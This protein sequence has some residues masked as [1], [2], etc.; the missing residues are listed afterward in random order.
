MLNLSLA[1]L[2]SGFDLTVQGVTTTSRDPVA[3]SADE[4]LMASG[5]G[6]RVTLW[7]MMTGRILRFIKT[8]KGIS[9]IAFEPNGKV[10]VSVSDN[11]HFLW[12]DV[13]SGAQVHELE[14]PPYTTLSAGSL[15][16][17]PDG[18]VMLSG[19]HDKLVVWD[20]KAR[21][22]KNTIKVSGAVT[23]LVA[24]SAQ[25]ALGIAGTSA[26]IIVDF[27]SGTIERTLPLASGV[28]CLKVSA[29]AKRAVVA[30]GDKLW[31]LDLT[32]MHSA[33]LEPV[34]VRSPEYAESIQG[35]GIN[36][37]L[38][39]VAY[40]TGK[41]IVAIDL[42][43]K[44]VVAS[45]GTSMGLN[46][47]YGYTRHFL[48]DRIL[49]VDD[50][51]GALVFS[52]LQGGEELRRVPF[53][54]PKD[55]TPHFAPGSHTIWYTHEDGAR[56]FDFELGTALRATRARGMFGTFS[57]D[58]KHLLV[59]RE[60]RV[61]G[62]RRDLLELWDLQR[63]QLARTFDVPP[64]ERTSNGNIM[65]VS[66]QLSRDGTRATSHM[67]G[68]NI[69]YVWDTR[70]GKLVRAID[71]PFA[72]GPY[73]EV[74]SPDGKQVISGGLTGMNKYA[75]A[76]FDVGTGQRTEEWS[77]PSFYGY[78][79]ELSSDGRFLVWQDHTGGVFVRDMTTKQIRNY[80]GKSFSLTRDS[81][82]LVLEG[83]S[84]VSVVGLPEQQLKRTI[85]VAAYTPELSDDGNY[86]VGRDLSGGF[87]LMN[88]SNKQ[89]VWFLTSSDE[90]IAYTDDGYFDG[91]KGG[92]QLLNVVS[93]MTVFALDQ[94]AIARNRPEILLDRLG[95]GSADLNQ[96]YKNQYLKRLRKAGITEAQ[97]SGEF[98][99][100]N[101]RISKVSVTGKTA[102]IAASCSDD[103]FE[104]ERYQVFVNDVPL[105]GARGKEAKGKSAALSDKIQLTQ[106]HNKIELSCT[107]RAGAESYRA[108]AAASS[109]VE[110]KSAL[111][112]LAFGVSKYKS[113]GLDLGFA[114]KDAEDLAK[115]LGGF[116][117]AHVKTFLNEAVT[118]R[119][120]TEAKAFVQKATPDDVFVLFIAGHGV[121]DTD[122]EATYYYLTHDADPAA[123]STTAANFDQ[124]EDL[125]QGIA[126][127]RKLFLMDTCESG[128]RD[129]DAPAMTAVDLKAGVRSRGIVKKGQQAAAP[130]P[131]IYLQARD[132][133]IYNDLSRRSGAVVFSSSR[134]G[135]LSYED[136]V[137]QNGFFTSA[138][139][140]AL[141]SDA[142]DANKD[143]RVSLTELRQYVVRAVD[144]RSKG[145]Q[146]P[147]IDRDN[148]SLRLELPIK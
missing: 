92:A 98:H 36:G 49:E 94:F 129:E 116:Q 63:D 26:L 104:L 46:S 133:F 74:L 147:T 51:N 138:I 16:F 9:G 84:S 7:D 32:K 96:H 78:H 56:S 88:L 70:T 62:H 27:A 44:K 65:W 148:Q 8:K 28:A 101:A 19:A 114:H 13:L 82:S 106:G 24:I 69:L 57:H 131:R 20:A 142:A 67:G 4:R 21:T 146:H 42:T 141:S 43:T 40:N 54:I 119:A 15:A 55:R 39:Y 29:D 93:G 113:P 41:S 122:P 90:W 110:S 86:L 109:S 128:E 117:P 123:L 103:R 140:K 105:Y 45:F 64:V 134:G 1:L 111:Y 112:V 23:E 99:A 14:S 118:T 71:K 121:H 12:H 50:V 137:L 89:R 135:E 124:I 75:I 80:A 33:E 127:R 139:L 100:P 61:S 91:S 81:K 11:G 107:N 52:S 47:V 68:E 66:P 136:N 60:I 38:V 144:E 87:F 102:T 85:D 34:K 17:T 30:Q 59:N 53:I 77:V 83:A 22:V 132:R 10:V 31:V 97:L 73:A 6:G 130:S 126:P 25:R 18:A 76:V 58:G 125:L 35:V 143:K 37:N 95:F 120:I 115:L 2:L 145:L 3:L 48:Q 108:L 5:G 79:F 72:S